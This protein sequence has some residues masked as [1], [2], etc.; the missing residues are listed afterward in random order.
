MKGWFRSREKE[1][2]RMA[3]GGLLVCMTLFGAERSLGIDRL[4]IVHFAAAFAVLGVLAGVHHM[5]V[6]GRLLCLAGLFLSL[7]AGSFADSEG[8]L[9]FWRLF[10]RW[11]VGRGAA[12]GEWELAFGLLQTALIAAACYGIQILFERLPGCKQGAAVLLLGILI[13]CLLTRREMNHFG[14]AFMICFFLLTWQEWVQSHWEKR[15]LGENSA[16]AYSFRLLPFMFLYLLFLLILPAP[17][18]PYDWGWAK[19]IYHQLRETVQEY[20]QRMKWENQE[21]F[22]MAFTGFSEEGALGGNLQEEAGE[23]MRVQVKPSSM[24]YLYLTGGVYDTFDGRGWSER[25]PEV[26]GGAFLDAAQ[27]LYA[28]RSYNER[29]QRDYLKEI[30]VTIRYEDFNTGYVFAPLKTWSVEEKS[31]TAAEI[32][33]GDG[34]LRWNVQRGFGTEYNLRYFALNTGQPQFDIFLEDTGSSGDADRPGGVSQETGNQKI[35]QEVS[36]ECERDNGISISRQNLEDYERAVCEQYLGEV[37]LSEEVESALQDIVGAAET[38]LEKLRAIEKYLSTLHYTLIPGKLP[39]SIGDAGDFLDY[40]LLES[41]QG[42]CT[43]FA[44]AFVLLARAEGIPARYVQGYCV[45][46]GEQEEAVVVSQ[47]AHAWPE[48]YFEGVGWIPFEPTPGYGSCRYDPWRLQQPPGDAEESMEIREQET[49]PEEDEKEEPGDPGSLEGIETTESGKDADPAY[50]WGM[51]GSAAW[52][53]LLSC[54]T[55]LVFEHLLGKYR[56]RKKSPQEQLRTEVLLNIKVLSLLMPERESWETLEE[57]REKSRHQW[58]QKRQQKEQQEERKAGKQ[59]ENHRREKPPEERK[60]Q[61]RQEGQRRPEGQG[62]HKKP[63]GQGSLPLRFI[64]DYEEVIYGGK[65]AGEEMVMNAVRER[66][67][68]LEILKQERRWGWIY[69]KIRLYFGRYRF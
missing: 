1:L 65:A 47:M 26:P 69:C 68:L 61:R 62:R 46:I 14:M 12:P 41:R 38:E 6:R 8:S 43:Y 60:G 66:A 64:E 59:Q 40:F 35:W 53:V 55:L 24:E 25:P 45:P 52:V 42:Y 23:V 5:A 50:F 32:D 20:T 15:R 17:E 44:T 19:A 22:G 29:Y 10:F 57:F 21:G 56:Y 37:K 33:S 16:L 30:Q 27:T 51:F 63:E 18:K 36:R 58:G 13:F 39:K 7:C 2:Y 34:T 3:N 4:G 48:A 11:L 31:G 28:V 54:G 49:D 67:G 9:D